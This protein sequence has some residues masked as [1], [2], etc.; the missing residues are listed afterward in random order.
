M[1]R[2]RIPAPPSMPPSPRILVAIMFLPFALISLVL[3][4]RVNASV[5]LEIAS[6]NSNRTATGLLDMLA[7]QIP[8]VCLAV[9]WAWVFAV[10]LSTGSRSLTHRARKRADNAI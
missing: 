5:H 6:Q 9:L 4:W 8:V 2:R 7:N 3:A 10:L 1:P